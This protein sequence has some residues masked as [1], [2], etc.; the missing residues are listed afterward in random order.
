MCEP[1]LPSPCHAQ[2]CVYERGHIMD[3]KLLESKFARMGARLRIQPVRRLRTNPP[4]TLDVRSDA[5]GEFFEIKLRKQDAEIDV[6]DLRRRERHLLLR[7]RANGDNDLFLCGHDE[8]HWF[9]AAVPE[10]GGV[11]NVATAM[12]ALKPP[13][14]RAA[15]AQQGVKGKDRRGRKNA[16]Y[17]RQGEWFFLPAPHL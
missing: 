10:R 11:S 6:L 1:R 4:L 14:V 5:K 12:E 16:A 8:R 13:E 2:G 15:Q 9:V 7:A 3:A 17:R